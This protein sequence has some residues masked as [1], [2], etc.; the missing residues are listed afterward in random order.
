M[1]K[2]RAKELYESGTIDKIEVGTFA[3]LKEIYHFLFQDVYDFAGKMRTDNI[4]KRNTRF[5]PFVYAGAVVANI[6]KMTT[7]HF[8]QGC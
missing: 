2:R 5:A 3:G 6:G 7:K 8:R 1:T 4:A